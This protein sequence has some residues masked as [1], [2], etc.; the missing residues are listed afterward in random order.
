MKRSLAAVLVAA[1]TAAGSPKIIIE[2]SADRWMYPSNVTPGA[3]TQAS[4][5]SALPGAGGLDDRWGF[6]LIA[7]DTGAVVPAGLPPEYYQIRSVKVTAMIAQDNLFVY[8]PSYDEWRTY[9]TPSVPAAVADPDSGRPLELHGAGFRNGE[10]AATF[11][12]TSPYGGNGQ[13]GTRSAFPFGFD[14]AGVARDVSS[15][16]S[17]QFESVPW[18]VGRHPELAPGDLVPEGSV[19]TFTLDPSLPGVDAYLRG[20]L[21][22]GRV[23]FSLTS[24]HPATQQA[25]EFVAYYT[26]DDFAHQFSM[27][28]DPAYQGGIAPTLEVDAEISLPLSI[29]RDG[30]TVSLGWPEFAGFTFTLQASPDLSP[31][32]W[33]PVHQHAATS[34]GTGS[35]SEPLLPGNRFYRLG[36]IRTP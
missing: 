10:T 6:F 33:Q 19:M 31:G 11:L 14:A 26:R 13:P 2:P 35:H 16:V 5:F 20:A 7:F 23:W 22:S 17:G 3:R 32:T 18:A 8:D 25:G 12:E 28:N 27:A 34:A 1:S 24:L 36:I 4:T 21:S 15:N 29:T 9:G 30:G